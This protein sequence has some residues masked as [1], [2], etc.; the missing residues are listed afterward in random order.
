MFIHFNA[1]LLAHFPKFRLLDYFHPSILKIRIPSTNGLSDLET[2][3]DVQYTANIALVGSL[4]VGD[5]N[6]RKYAML[7]SIS[8]WDFSTGAIL[9][10]YTRSQPGEPI[11][12]LMEKI[13]PFL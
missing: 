3:D 6:P 4:F 9:G 10:C 7:S 13:T 5:M 12:E 2:V 11:V 8:A 1:L